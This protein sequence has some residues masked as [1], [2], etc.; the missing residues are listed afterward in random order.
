[1]LGRTGVISREEA[2]KALDLH[3]TIAPLASEE[4]SISLSLGRIVAEKITSPEDLP[5]FDRSTMDGFAVR[6]ADTF[7][8]AESRPALVTIVGDIAMGTMPDRVLSVGEAMK[9]ATGGALPKGADAVVMLEQTQAV[10]AGQIEVVKPVAPL[11]NVVQTGDDI[12]RGEVIL[13]R[14]HRMRPQDM[15]A[16]AGVG[17]TRVRVF[18]KP[19]AAIINTG[20]EVVPADFAPAPGQVRDINS[21]NLEGLISQAGCIPVKK[22]IIPDEYGRLREALDAA[23]RDCDLVLM[24]GGSSVGTMDLTARVINDLGRPGVLVHGVSI[25]PGKPIIMGV[26]NTLAKQV[27]VF[28]LPGHPAAVSIC[29]EVFVK[30][31]LERMTGEIPHPALAGVSPY[32]SVKA[33]LARSISSSPGREDHVR[34]TLEKMDDGLLA[35]PVFGASGLISTLVNA[36]GTV[37]VPVNKIGIEVGEEVDVRLF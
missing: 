4:L 26:L 37:V 30:P 5:E 10:D 13:N 9:I 16:L 21:Y 24:T 20:N 17:I 25:K 15:G 2:L 6:S 1:M 23:L 3:L 11:E 36:A 35:R 28:G 8:A 12:K 19:K 22:G 29:F 34:V 33:K 31:V 32:R 18:E 14:G 27:P 7:G